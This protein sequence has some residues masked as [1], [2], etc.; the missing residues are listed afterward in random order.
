M[1]L[2]NRER[3]ELVLRTGENLV[4][5][6]D[7]HRVTAAEIESDQVLQWTITTPLYNIGEQVNNLDREFCDLYPDVPWMM[8]AGMRHRL[9]HDYEGTNWSIVAKTV[10]E[11]IPAFVSQV[12][13]ILDIL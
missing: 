3:L 5:F 7:Q 11:D 2:G 4:T 8:V 6:L 1:R 13:T 12:R 9:V 10:L